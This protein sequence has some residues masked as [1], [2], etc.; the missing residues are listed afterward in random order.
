MALGADPGLSY[1]QTKQ[2]AVVETGVPGANLEIDAQS[3]DSLR[4]EGTFVLAKAYGTG[5]SGGAYIPYIR[6]GMTHDFED[7]LRSIVS[8]FE[9]QTTDFTVFG[10]VGAKTVGIIGVGVNWMISDRFSVFFDY[11]AEIGSGYTQHNVS[12]GGRVRF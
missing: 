1:A 5:S 11:N 4:V 10:E 6:L 2:S 3:N 9:G 7:D 12:G 8:N